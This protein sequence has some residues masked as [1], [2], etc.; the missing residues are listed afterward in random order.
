MSLRTLYRDIGALRE[1]HVPVEAEPGPG[2]GVRIDARR[3]TTQVRFREPEV[4]ALWLSAELAKRAG[5]A[6]P[7]GRAAD[8]G[9]DRIFAALP[10][11]RRRELRV[12]LRRVVVAEWAPD[13]V[14]A[15]AGAPPPELVSVFEEAFTSRLGLAF[16]YVDRHGA[17]SRRRVEPHG[18]L[19][20]PP[21]WY[22]LAFDVDKQEPRMFRMDRVARPRVARDLAFVPRQEVVEA[23]RTAESCEAYLAARR[24]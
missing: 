9:L 23:M 18:L 7:W 5:A 12:L 8:A 20:Y 15:G 1:R 14:R 13:S 4:V 6:L 19:V 16:D 2:G 3:A 11:V 17:P 10:E 24:A 21:V 22:V